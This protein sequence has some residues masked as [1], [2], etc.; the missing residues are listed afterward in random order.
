MRNWCSLDP[1][2]FWDGFS[3]S[4]AF[5][6]H[7]TNLMH[8][9][10]ASISHAGSQCCLIFWIENFFAFNWTHQYRSR[11][12]WHVVASVPYIELILVTLCLNSLN[13]GS[14][15]ENGHFFKWSLNHFWVF[16][17]TLLSLN[18]ISW[19]FCQKKLTGTFLLGV[20]NIEPFC[21]N[22]KIH[23]TCCFELSIQK[24]EHMHMDRLKYVKL[25][26]YMC[27]RSM[28]SFRTRFQHQVCRWGY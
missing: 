20:S 18:M 1:S 3:R 12:C 7:S 8:L 17:S 24:P 21:A 22:K 26:I 23:F 15:P 25:L 10:I 14:G 9:F 2:H 16:E 13:R 19:K 4:P 6:E 28:Q 11:L 5:L 27:E